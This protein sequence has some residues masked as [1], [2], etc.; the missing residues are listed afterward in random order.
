MLQVDISCFQNSSERCHP[1]NEKKL[2]KGEP[3]AAAPGTWH[4][5]RRDPTPCICHGLSKKEK[6]MFHP[7]IEHASIQDSHNLGVYRSGM[8]VM[9]FLTFILCCSYVRWG[10][11]SYMP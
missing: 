9:H 2:R 10:V 1:A 4:M 11:F 6:K 7:C 5:A 8:T 3:S